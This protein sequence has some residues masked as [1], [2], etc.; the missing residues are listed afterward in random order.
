MWQAVSM[1]SNWWIGIAAAVSLW[2][3]AV[4][5]AGESPTWISKRGLFTLSYE[6]SIEPITIN[7]MHNWMLHIKTADGAVVTDAVL[8]VVGGMPEHDH[9]LPTRPRITNNLGDGNYR[10]EGLRFH[11][12]GEWLLEVTIDDGERTDSVNISLSI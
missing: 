3:P 11:M 5:F 1:K 2:L 6:S 8:S 10:L 9:G 4:C 12:A 7:R